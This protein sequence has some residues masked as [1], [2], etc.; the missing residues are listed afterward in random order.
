MGVQPQQPGQ[1]C[2]V[3]RIRLTDPHEASLPMV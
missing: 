3:V 2:D 1:T